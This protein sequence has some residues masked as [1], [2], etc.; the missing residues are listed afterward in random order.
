MG[1]YTGLRVNMILRTD[2]P[3]SVR[4]LL[5]D[6]LS[7]GPKSVAPPDHPLFEAGGRWEYMLL[8]T[9]AYLEPEFTPAST[10]SDIELFVSFN[11]KNYGD[12]IENFLHWIGPYVE[13]CHGGLYRQEDSV[14]QLV[15]WEKGA[16]FIDGNPVEARK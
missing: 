2:V 7:H 14:A 10:L 5:R 9:S 6:M 8:G 1:H 13:D 12:E 3:Q 11:I 16:F 15:T 4:D